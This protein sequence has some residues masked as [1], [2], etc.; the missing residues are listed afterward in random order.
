[1]RT[2]VCEDTDT[3]ACVGVRQANRDSGLTITKAAE[4]QSGPLPDT[5]PSDPG[6]ACR[7]PLFVSSTQPAPISTLP[8]SLN[9]AHTLPIQ[10]LAGDLRGD[11]SLLTVD[12]IV[13]TA[14][15]NCTH[16]TDRHRDISTLI[17]FCSRLCPSSE[18]SCR[19]PESFKCLRPLLSLSVLLPVAP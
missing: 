17:P 10:T 4:P 7:L 19:V 16:C 8:S 6:G 3:C 14:R 2:R 9:N 13:V 12:E 5:S 11:T 15:E 18:G 1:M